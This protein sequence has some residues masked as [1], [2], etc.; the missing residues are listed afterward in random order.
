MVLAVFSY[1]LGQNGCQLLPYKIS[2]SFGI[3][4]I[5]HG[6]EEFCF[7]AGQCSPT[8]FQHYQGFL[9][10]PAQS[11]DLNI[12]ENVWFY[13]KNNLKFDP[14]CRKDQKEKNYCQLL[15]KIARA[16][17]VLGYRT[18]YTEIQTATHDFE[19]YFNCILIFN[20]QGFYRK[21]YN[22]LSIN[23]PSIVVFQFGSK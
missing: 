12:I 15:L 9:L 16:V 13:L 23:F 3:K 17:R 19:T 5:R 1:L 22:F 10:R 14:R 18:K 7:S 20:S 6:K 2:L 8:S 11:P 21:L 4:N